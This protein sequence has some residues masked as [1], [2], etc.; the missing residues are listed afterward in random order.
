MKRLSGLLVLGVLAGCQQVPVTPEK[1]ATFLP[2]YH[3]AAPISL[4]STYAS[5]KLTAECEALDTQKKC[6]E[7][8]LS[9]SQFAQILTEKNWFDEVLTDS[10][11]ADYELL[12]ASLSAEGPA[13]KQKALTLHSASGGLW[14]ADVVP[15][16]FSEITVQWRGVEID[17]QQFRT[18]ALSDESDATLS[19]E[20][21]ETWWLAAIKK[22]VFSAEY[23]FAALGASDYRS[24]LALPEQIGAFVLED[25]QYYPDPFKGV[26]TRYSHPEYEDA[27]I[28]ITV[29]PVM[30][31][32]SV[33]VETRLTTALELNLQE[34]RQIATV[35]GLQL[36]TDSPP[37]SFTVNTGDTLFKGYRMAVHAESDKSE[38]IFATTYV[39]EMK[40]K[41]VTL[42]TTF[43]PRVADELIAVALPSIE[44]PGESELMKAIRRMASE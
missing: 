13:P 21:L 18:L 38:P 32:L 26:I 34:A 12:I 8:A 14:P 43:P 44:V 19:Q 24:A 31:D 1:P 42:A 10:D 17:S 35:Q 5:S 27:L 40:D 37:E 7:D 4:F 20:V 16:Y 36:V 9:G 30:V 22:R 33:P 25:S 3:V 2:Q 41:L 23:L 39:F 28:D 6:K 11:N 15:Y 29:S